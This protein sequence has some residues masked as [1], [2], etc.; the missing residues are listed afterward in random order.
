MKGKLQRVKLSCHEILC[1]EITYYEYHEF[2]FMKFDVAFHVVDLL[3]L[4]RHIFVL[5]D[6]VVI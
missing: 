3:R 6:G 4:G 5:F 2:Y 1:H